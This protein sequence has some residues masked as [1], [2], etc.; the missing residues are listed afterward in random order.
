[1]VHF[2]ASIAFKH[3]VGIGKFT[4]AD[5]MKNEAV[6]TYGSV[7]DVMALTTFS[8]ATLYKFQKTHGFPK[9]RKISTRSVWIMR[10]VEEWMASALG[11]EK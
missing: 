10:E 1:M 3:K 11:V 2:V 9:P 7:K 6:N 8:R 4:G 5:T